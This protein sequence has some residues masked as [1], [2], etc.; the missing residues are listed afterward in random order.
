MVKT[1][2]IEQIIVAERYPV[3]MGFPSTPVVSRF[4][5][6]C[7]FSCICTVK[8]PAAGQMQKAS[9]TGSFCKCYFNPSTSIA[10]LHPSLFVLIIFIFAILLQF[11]Q[12]FYILCI[13]V[14]VSRSFWDSS[15]YIPRSHAP[16]C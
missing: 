11:A 6:I 14:I 15:S 3:A 7:S 9:G 16:L 12:F 8:Y 1:F 4:A 5:Y 13:P 2:T 10:G